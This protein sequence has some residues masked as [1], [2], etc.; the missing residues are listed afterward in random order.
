MSR[1]LGHPALSASSEPPA[2]SS[3]CII[4]VSYNT[5]D[6]T[7]ACL[8]SIY[9][10]DDSDRVRVIVVDN[11]SGDG[12][13]EAIRKTFPQADVVDSGSNMGFARAVNLAADHSDE[14]YLLLLNPD[15][16]L[17]P[18]SLCALLDFAGA[19]P[20][21]GIYGGR[22]VDENGVT[23]P[24]SCWGAPTL[25]GLACF[26]TGVSTAFP[27]SRVFNPE[28]LGRWQRDSVREVPVI[29]GCLLL[30]RRSDFLAV[31]GM[32]PRFFLYSEDVEF[33]LRAKGLGLS[34]VVVPDA[35]I[36]HE[37]GAASRDNG[38]SKMCMVMA[39][40]ATMLRVTW[41]PA[42]AQLGVQFLR[43]GAR[44][45]AALERVSGRERR[46]WTEVWER[47]AAWEDGYPRAHMLLFGAPG[48]HFTTS[49]TSDDT[50]VPTAGPH[51]TPLKEMTK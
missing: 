40:K 1:T 43:S 41:P 36:R 23:D 46:M 15:A 31:G 37:G 19:H 47:R 9:A 6:K 45:R 51:S 42:K 25:W 44:L 21:Y 13:P 4:V 11:D 26:G 49:G 38:G 39:G 35:V 30:V 22:I 5:R 18:G 48:A 10:Q 33:C 29:T 50:A 24:S 16:L 8:E 12:S 17:L 32:D 3:L 14:D 27:R 7:V 34:S 28:S 2:A 20:Q